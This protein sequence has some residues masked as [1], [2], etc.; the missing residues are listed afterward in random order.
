MAGGQANVEQGL[1]TGLDIIATMAWWDWQTPEMLE[2]QEQDANTQTDGG[3]G[4]M[5]TFLIPLFWL[6]LLPVVFFLASSSRTRVR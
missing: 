3:G 5:S 1:Q 6:T 2:A 4:S